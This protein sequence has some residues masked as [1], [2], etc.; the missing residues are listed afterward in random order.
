[1]ADEDLHEARERAESLLADVGPQAELTLIFSLVEVADDEK[2]L[3]E[4]L[5]DALRN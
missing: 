1:M 5:A 4:Q 3:T 2:W